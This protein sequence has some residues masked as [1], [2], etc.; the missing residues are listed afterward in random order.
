MIDI[1]QLFI[2][3][4]Q[5]FHSE[6]IWSLLLKINMTFPAISEDDIHFKQNQKC[7][8]III[9]ILWSTMN[10]AGWEKRKPTNLN[11]GNP[12]LYLT[13]FCLIRRVQPYR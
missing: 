6:P 5:S 1:I 10:S 4:I 13:M 7:L 12:L 8:G 2:H 3:I 9:F 11:A